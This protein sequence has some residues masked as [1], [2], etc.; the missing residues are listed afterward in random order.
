MH[1][2]G[3]ALVLLVP[4]PFLLAVGLLTVLAVSFANSL[5]THGWRRTNWAITAFELDREGLCSVQLGR[6][7]DWRECEVLR[8]VIHPWLALLWLR[9]KGR[10]WPT[11]LVLAAD[12]VEPE[13][14][15]RLRAR[16]SLETRAA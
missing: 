9:L 11:G 3:M 8:A 10:R 16:L 12:A 5:G 15:R 6:Q 1:L 2:G 7:P 14:F 4:L 13:A